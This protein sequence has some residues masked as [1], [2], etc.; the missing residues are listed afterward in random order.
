MALYAKNREEWVVTD[1]A[2]ITSGITVITLYE[3]LGKDSIEYILD[4]T[5]M[6]T[7]VCQ[8]DKIENLLQL[9]K[10]GKVKT[11][12]HIITFEEVKPVQVDKVALD[13]AGLTLIHYKDVLS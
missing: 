4:Q 11:L 2:C 9:K 6:K 1:L 10:E 13:A 5:S 3:T 7:C 8:A 12:T